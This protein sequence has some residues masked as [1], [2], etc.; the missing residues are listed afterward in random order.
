MRL[1]ATLP[2]A[3]RASLHAVAR[4]R[5][6]ALRGRMLAPDPVLRELEDAVARRDPPARDWTEREALLATGQAELRD[7]QAGLRE[8]DHAGAV[9]ARLEDGSTLTLRGAALDIWQTMAAARLQR[10]L[11]AV[12]ALEEAQPALLAQC[13]AARAARIKALTRK[14]VEHSGFSWHAAPSAEDDALPPPLRAATLAASNAHGQKVTLHWRRDEANGM[15]WLRWQSAGGRAH[16][17]GS[18]AGRAE[19]MAA[20]RPLALAA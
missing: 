6:A 17:D 20:L 7:I 16:E 14:L 5:L 11:P 1:T 4:A 19:V 3:N 18:V 12:L 13:E 15:E 8:A 10:L 9:E 2:G